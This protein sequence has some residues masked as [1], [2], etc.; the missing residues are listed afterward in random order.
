MSEEISLQKTLNQIKDVSSNISWLFAHCENLSFSD[1]EKLVN[2]VRLLH[3]TDFE[4]SIS[5]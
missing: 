5:I 1:Y 2:A 4:R 3:I